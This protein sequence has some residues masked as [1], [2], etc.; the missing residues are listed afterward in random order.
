MCL[1]SLLAPFLLAP[2]AAAQERADSLTEPLLGELSWELGPTGSRAS[3]RGLS[4]AS[5]GLQSSLELGGILRAFQVENTDDRPAAVIRYDALL[6]NPMDRS[7]IASKRF[8]ARHRMASLGVEEAV[9][10]MGVA[11]NQLVDELINWTME[12]GQVAP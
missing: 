11:A 8:E 1:V 5:E 7:I 4:A 10:A 3:L 9:S 2:F 12:Q 6:I